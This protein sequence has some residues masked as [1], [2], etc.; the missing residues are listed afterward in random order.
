M[1]V[2][3][4]AHRLAMLDRKLGPED[5]QKVEEAAGKSLSTLAS[6]LVDALDE[7]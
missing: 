3:S 5:K 4:L 1:A 7:R 6:D 2:S